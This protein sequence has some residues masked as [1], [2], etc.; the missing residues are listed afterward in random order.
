MSQYCRDRHAR[1][2]QMKHAYGYMNGVRSL[3]CSHRFQQFSI[4]VQE[5]RLVFL[6]PAYNLQKIDEEVTADKR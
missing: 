4:F 2:I 3:M 5:S 6:Q 1:S